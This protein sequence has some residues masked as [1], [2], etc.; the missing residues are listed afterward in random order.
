MQMKK[1]IVVDGVDS[2]GKETN[3]NYIYELLKSM[4]ENVIRLS[5]PDYDSP[6]SSL[7]KMY[8]GG[9]FGDNP[10]DVNAYAASV[11]YAADR[12]ASYKTSWENFDGIIVADRYTTS[13]M[14]HQ[15]AK[16]DDE[17]EKNQF[18]DWLE[19]LEYE[20]FGIPK[21]DK[22]IF[23]NMPVWAAE[24]LMANRKNKITGNEKKD[25][26][27][28]NEE[29]LKKSYDNAMYVAK[30]FGWTIVNCT[31]GGRIKLLDEIQN[32]LKEIVLNS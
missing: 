21:P 2:S 14:V 20:K 12:Y 3:T 16:I 28:R 13:N 1:L 23:L 26:H 8:L 25:I 32:E 18:L 22:I 31:D 7:V 9:E 10:S 17:T 19:D 5:F 11:F 27:E 24:K 4:G 30:K 15:A 6:S 29:Y